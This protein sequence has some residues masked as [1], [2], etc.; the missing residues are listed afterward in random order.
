VSKATLGLL[1]VGA[2]VLVGGA[3]SLA[4]QRPDLNGPLRSDSKT[5]VS[6]AVDASQPVTWGLPVRNPAVSP[7]QVEAV[8]PVDVHGLDIL[9]IQVSSVD[10]VTG[11]GSLVIEPGWPPEEVSLRDVRSAAGAIMPVVGTGDPDL[12]F[13]VVVQRSTPDQP[14]T[15]AAVRVRYQFEQREYEA[16][17]PWSLQLSAPIPS[18][19]PANG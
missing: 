12:Q 9:A 19:V 4:F 16:L 7:I 15:I 8:E 10:P 14:G 1:A 5:T 3:A 6:Y 17:L 2:L 18:A 13:L 11:S